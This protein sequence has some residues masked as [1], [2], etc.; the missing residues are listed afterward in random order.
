MADCDVTL[1]YCIFIQSNSDL[2][3]D[4]SLLCDKKNRNQFIVSRAICETDNEDSDVVGVKR[5]KFINMDI[6][7]TNATHKF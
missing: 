1:N 5:A 4:H 6:T 3:L 7:V 2:K